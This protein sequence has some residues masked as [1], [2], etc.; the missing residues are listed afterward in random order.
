MD[1]LSVALIVENRAIADGVS[2][3]LESHPVR[4]L[5][6]TNELPSDWSEL[7]ARIERV[8]P[9]LVLLDLTS[10]H[11]P[12]EEVMRMLGRTSV[13]PPVFV[14][15]DQPDS[16]AIL[17]ALRAGAS[18]F[19]FL[20]FDDTLPQALARFKQTRQEQRQQTTGKGKLVGF[21]SAKGGCGAT[22]MACHFSVGLTERDNKKVLLADLDFQSGVIDFL[23]KVKSGYSIADAVNNIQRLDD[24]YW[25]GL[26]SNGIP[27]LEIITAPSS[28]T[29]KVVSVDGLRQVLSFA[30]RHYDWTVMD[31]GRNLTP[32]TLSILPL[33]DETYLV[34]TPEIPALH[35]AKRIIRYLLDTGFDP[36][37]LRVI[38]NRAPRSMDVTL[39]ELGDMLGLPI[40]ATVED[41]F[42]ALQSSYSEGQL[43]RSGGKIG[44]DMDRLVSRELGL[45]P[46]KK[47]RFSLFS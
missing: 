19:L 33:L 2:K 6:E 9:E 7:L 10:L 14:L 3:A 25:Q 30:S 15:N 26:V 32:D 11:Q 8:R 27:N 5:F 35:Q 41:D 1:S 36:D 38:L 22:T 24:S 39:D 21:L 4:V 13:N 18:E 12:L 40:Y 44:K 37:K 46:E 28:P 47:H 45:A 29:N 16:D 20:P 43:V 42:Q 17:G 34:V 23:A 31:L